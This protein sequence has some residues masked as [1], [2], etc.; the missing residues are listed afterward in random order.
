MN[1]D[2]GLSGK[3]NFG[4]SSHLKLFLNVSQTKLKGRT[5]ECRSVKALLGRQTAAVTLLN[6]ENFDADTKENGNP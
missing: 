5:G 4:G 2:P 6:L 1:L 3:T